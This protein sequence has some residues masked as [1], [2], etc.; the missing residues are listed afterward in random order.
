MHTLPDLLQALVQMEGSD[1][2]LSIPPICENVV[3]PT[4]MNRIIPEIAMVP[5]SAASMLARVS[6]R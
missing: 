3:A 6:A 1:L 4:M 2:H 5:F